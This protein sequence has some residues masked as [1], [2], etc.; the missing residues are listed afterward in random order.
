MTFQPRQA[1]GNMAIAA[2]ITLR[3]GQ[4]EI[5]QLFLSWWDISSGSMGEFYGFNGIFMGY[6]LDIYGI[7]IGY[8]WDIYWIFIGYLLD[9][10]WIFIG[11]VLDIYWMSFQSV[12]EFT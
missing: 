10:Y 4:A 9:I 8:L 5:G 3:V 6:L 11:Y 12:G 7:F 1:T 2:A